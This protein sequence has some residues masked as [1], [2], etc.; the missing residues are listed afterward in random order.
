MLARSITSLGRRAVLAA[1]L[2]ALTAGASLTIAADAQPQAGEMAPAI[3][4]PDQTG[5]TVNLADYKGKWVV[6]YFYPKDQTP[7]CTTQACEFRDNIFEFRNAGAQI[8]GISV[9]D[10]ASH[11]AFAEMH[12]L[13]FPLLADS[14]K[15][16]A[17]RYGV[18]TK[19]GDNAI[20]SR[21]TFLV[22]PAGK[23]V[24]HYNVGRDDL[25]GH[26]KLVLSDI[27]TF[28]AKN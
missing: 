20:A 22:D 6:V 2:L 10:V 5:K 8:L 3:S 27:A 19:M 25:V 13:P 9:D 7:G 28:K 4:L 12:G 21:Q 15:A 18:L 14:T 1:G 24:K 17:T 26:S 23:I 16:T 11:K